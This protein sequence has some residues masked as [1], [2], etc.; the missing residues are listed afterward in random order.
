MDLAKALLGPLLLT[1][2][3]EASILVLWKEK[4]KGVLICSLLI[5]VVT[6][7]SLNLFVYFFPFSSVW[8][9]IAWI[10]LLELVIVLVEALAYEIVLRDVK[11]SLV[12]SISCNV[13]SFL[14]GLLINGL[15]F[16]L[17]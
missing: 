1:I 13:G 15:V 12:Y 6:N 14:I 17:G 3:L 10:V 4:K 8:V 11:K 16:I 2:L 7:V 9:Y 5:N